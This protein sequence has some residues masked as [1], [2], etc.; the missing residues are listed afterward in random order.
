M[1]VTLCF[2]SVSENIILI[3]RFGKRGWFCLFGQREQI[4]RMENC[5]K[6]FNI[7]TSES[8]ELKNKNQDCKGYSF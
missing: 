4:F 8:A 2:K 3:Y 5:V 6:G 1:S 7:V